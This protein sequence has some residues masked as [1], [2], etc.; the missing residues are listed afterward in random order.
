MEPLVL[1]SASPRR[2][3]ILE[4]LQIPLLVRPAPA[5]EAMRPGDTPEAYLARVVDAKLAAARAVCAPAEPR[6]VADTI[7]VDG[8]FIL[9]KPEDAAGAHRMLRRLSG[10]T[11]RVMSRFAVERG[12]VVHAE[13]V[14]TEVDFIALSDPEILGYVATGEGSDKA[15]AYAVQ[16][17]GSF[18][19]SAIRGSYTN[20]VGL[21]ACEV[22]RALLDVGYLSH[23]PLVS[24]APERP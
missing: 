24:R 21:P 16:G 23:F 7:V 4:T 15:G 18:L 9:G 1:V 14:V 12:S 20:V 13:T 22:V 11:H 6:L 17:I 3:E 10:R 8:A 19:V 5:D 2:R